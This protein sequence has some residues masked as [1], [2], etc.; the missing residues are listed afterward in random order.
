M[1][2]YLNL[3]LGK[4]FLVFVSLGFFSLYFLEYRD[5]LIATSGQAMMSVNSRTNSLSEQFFNY[6]LNIPSPT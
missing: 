6:Y 1:C 3:R 2:F 4:F 5:S